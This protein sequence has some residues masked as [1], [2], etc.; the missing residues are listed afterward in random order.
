MH[1]IVG[2]S[3]FCFPNGALIGVLHHETF[4]LQATRP[5]CANICPS[6]WG[7]NT[8]ALPSRWRAHTYCGRIIIAIVIRHLLILGISPPRGYLKIYCFH[9]LRSRPEQSY[10]DQ[11]TL[12]F[13][14]KGGRGGGIR[15]NL[16]E[17]PNVTRAK[18]T[19][20]EI[21]HYRPPSKR[22]AHWDL[23]VSA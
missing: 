12:D 21:P 5:S 15:D 20:R 10:E 3:L 19:S 22:G 17:C 14:K 7:R 16:Q 1:Y 8:A 4:Y 6:H 13:K 11:A 18:R 2:L 23:Y 9:D